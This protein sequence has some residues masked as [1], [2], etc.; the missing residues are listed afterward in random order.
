MK[1]FFKLK[2]KQKIEY[3]EE[4]E[5]CNQKNLILYKLWNHLILRQPFNQ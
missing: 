4:L 5:I 2:N 3:K 1:C